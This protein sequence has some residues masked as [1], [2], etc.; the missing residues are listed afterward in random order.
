MVKKYKLKS[1]LKLR[2][3]PKAKP[4][5]KKKK[6]NPGPTRYVKKKSTKA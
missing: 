5:P 1:G 3:K 6:Y 2:A 4:K